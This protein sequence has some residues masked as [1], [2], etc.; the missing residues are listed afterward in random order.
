MS[1]KEK[2]QKPF[3]EKIM[4]QFFRLIPKRGVS[5]Q[6][7]KNDFI[8]TEEIEKDISSDSPFS[9]RQKVIRELGEEVLK[10]KLE[11]K[12]IEKL[13]FCLKDLLHRDQAKECRH[14]VFWFLQRLVE[15]QY[16][17]LGIMRA[18][19]F[20][21]VKQH[22]HPEDTNECFKL[23]DTLTSM[24]KD[25]LYFEEEMGPFLLTWMPLVKIAGI[26]QEYLGLLLNV[27]K[28][29]AAYLDEE[30]VNGL[31]VNTCELSTSNQQVIVLKCLDV[32]DKIVCYSNLPTE[33][34]AVFIAAVCRTVN[35]EEYCQ[36]S[37]KIMR[38]LLGTHMGHSALY[39]MCR[40]LQE[41]ACRHDPL[42]LRG[43]VFHVNQALWGTR[44]LKSLNC[45]PASV[46][47]SF[48]HALNCDHPLVVYEVMLS[49]Q[50]LVNRC[51]VELHDPAW[52][53]ILAIIEAV[54]QH[55]ESASHS[56]NSPVASHL[57]ETIG[58]MEKLIELHQFNGSVSK[59]YELIERCSHSRPESSVLRLV[60][61][62]AQSIVPTKHMWLSKL[63]TLL[64][65]YFRQE[66]RTNVRI[67]VIEILSNVIKLN[68]MRYEDELI[69]RIVVPHFQHIASDTDVMVRNSCSELLV[70]LCLDCDTKRCTE[71]LDIL[72]KILNRPFDQQAADTQALND[73]ELIDVKTVVSGLVRVFTVKLHRLPSSHFIRVYRMLVTH[74]E[75]HYAKPVLFETSSHIRYK[76][77]NCFLKIRANSSYHL[78]CIDTTGVM[79]YSPYL[80]VLSRTSSTGTGSPPPA[81]PAVTQQTTSH[82][83]GQITHVSLRYAFKI[84]IT[85]LREEKD[86]DVLQLVLQE[87]PH[88]M[89][90]KALVLSKQGNNEI[91]HLAT[92]LC[93]M[94]TDRSLALPESLRN[95][96][97]LSR[98]EFH[99]S[100]LLVLASLASYHTHLEPACQQ[101]MIR[102]MVKFGL[103]PRCCSQHC[104]TALT[105][106]TLEMQ[107]VMVKLLP[108]V[109]LDLSK[110][111]TTP[112]IAIP[113]L[114]FLSTLT[115]LPTVFANFVGDQYMA[116]FAIAL[117]Y[118][119][120]FKFNHYTVSLAHHVI[121]VWFLKCRLPFRKDFVRFITTG[122]QTNAL[123]PFEETA[124]IKN[125]VAYLN[126]DSSNRKRSSSLTEQGSRRRDRPTVD[127][128][129]VNIDRALQTF[130]EEITETA[131]D[132]MARY[133]FSPC[134]ALPK[135]LP[136]AEFLLS[137]GQSMTWLLGNKVITVT[138]SGCSQKALKQG[139]CD[140]CFAFC[141]DHLKTPDT[142]SMA[143]RQNSSEHQQSTSNTSASSPT[144]ETKKM[145]TGSNE[146]L[147]QLPN[148]LYQLASNTRPGDKYLCSCWCQGWAEVHV[149]RPTGKY[150]KQ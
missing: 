42:L 121:A 110:I 38:N 103:M 141:R 51:G 137:G 126:E 22:D 139:L 83:S 117:P 27:I 95:A 138:T 119:N 11:D 55:I 15:G 124:L 61:Y 71:I 84:F 80:C 24:G 74:L 143:T 29:N 13:W 20:R 101:R 12:A 104:I 52:D 75:N 89:Q 43:A 134:S 3:Q 146:K 135:R 54:I 96:T 86:W 82:Q 7:S 142:S 144:E 16:D 113:V 94:L 37:W 67:K 35:Q 88:V 69:E 81:S 129:G 68:R 1:S 106:C 123:T 109:L 111:S 59:L 2:E 64:Q 108:E 36:K 100:V 72:D 33:S 99:S 23:L 40:V 49:V 87:I 128:R 127:L 28:F 149:R 79:R 5:N 136:T 118:T 32:L 18:H 131:I 21:V 46:L 145:P 150:I 78:G 60:S 14:L 115:H 50:G 8:L 34:L 105:T 76:I 73:A 45:T 6:K 31:L 17:R 98:S 47:P 65:R 41:P 62:T 97:K 91:D 147:E 130:Y 107:E 53:I 114:E 92:A 66:T 93:A 9:T 112:P 48:L 39:T 19:F 77:F 90:N 70:D 63:H 56:I 125:D 30:V 120:P 140:K 44:P 132:L 133:T 102:C 116:V 57:H 25:L 148:K 122:L 26:S 10:N 85:C 4:K 58:N